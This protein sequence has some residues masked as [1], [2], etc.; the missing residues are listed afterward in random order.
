MPQQ[1]ENPDQVDVPV[2][3]GAPGDNGSPTPATAQPSEDNR[4]LM[5]LLSNPDIQA[6]LAAVRAGKSVKVTPVEDQPPAPAVPPLDESE[7]EDFDDDTK[8]V[9][10]VIEQ[11]IKSHLRPLEDQV[12]GLRNIADTYQTQEVNNQITSVSKK[13]QDFSKY[14][15]AMSQLARGKGAG[16]SVEQLYVL[17]KH[18]AGELR[19][20]EP[21]THSERPTPTP[22]T[23]KPTAARTRPKDNKS[24]ATS[25]GRK[26]FN[27]ALADALDKI[28]TSSVW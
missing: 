27:S 20:S 10:S 7:L 3:D 2:E 26:D 6:V 9:I 12:S 14:R 13:Y 22:R 28:D 15:S 16:L 4:L 21:S 24:N 5:G 8:K 19:L 25:H 17:A 1:V 23:G 18:E 11:R